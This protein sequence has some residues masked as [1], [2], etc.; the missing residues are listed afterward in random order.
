[1]RCAAG[2]AAQRL[3]DVTRYLRQTLAIEA[4]Y[5]WVQAHDSLYFTGCLLCLRECLVAAKLAEDGGSSGGNAIKL[6]RHLRLSLFVCLFG[7][8]AFVLSVGVCL[9]FLLRLSLFL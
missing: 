4:P 5:L 7:V 9:V 3:L 1:M 2:P 8:V 6:T